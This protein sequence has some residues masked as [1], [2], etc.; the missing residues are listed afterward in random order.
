MDENESREGAQSV[1]PAKERQR[2]SKQSLI[3][4]LRK[5][6]SS[7]KGQSGR[8]ISSDCA[9]DVKLPLDEEA[10]HKTEEM[11]AREECS[12]ES[13]SVLI[14]DLAHALLRLR[15]QMTTCHTFVAHQ[16]TNNSILPEF[17]HTCLREANGTSLMWLLGRLGKHID[18]SFAEMLDTHTEAAPAE[19]NPMPLSRHMAAKMMMLLPTGDD[20]AAEK[21]RLAKIWDGVVFPTL[22][23][24]TKLLEA[25]ARVREKLSSVAYQVSPNLSV[26]CGRE[27][28]GLLIG[29]TGSMAS[30]SKLTPSDVLKLGSDF[31]DHD[32]AVISGSR[33]LSI[34]DRVEW[35]LAITEAGDRTT[36]KKNLASKVLLAVRFDAFS[37][38]NPNAPASYGESLRKQILEKFQRRNTREDTGDAP[39]PR[40]EARE[41]TKRGGWKAR[42]R[43]KRAQETAQVT[44][45]TAPSTEDVSTTMDWYS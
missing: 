39:L 24:Y 17:V 13:T 41:T 3:D 38:S 6:K 5:D 20:R 42:L 30:L 44:H 12:K 45:G 28:A 21:D 8:V 36:L 32:A 34:L 40:P 10:L 1:Q 37:T 23:H 22:S 25:D 9:T 2:K 35:L 27:V 14:S 16:Y 33:Q 11:L 43:R 19:R 18:T 31:A 26:L 15:S 7:T 4:A 29:L